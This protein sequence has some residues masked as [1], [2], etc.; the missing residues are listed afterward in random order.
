MLLPDELQ[1]LLHDAGRRREV[2]FLFER[3]LALVEEKGKKE[4]GINCIN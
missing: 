4:N 3:L 1:V 2:Q